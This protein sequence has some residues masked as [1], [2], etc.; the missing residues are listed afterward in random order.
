MKC[1][2]CERE[3]LRSTV[4]VGATVSTAMCSYSFYDED[5]K[6]HYHNPNTV[7]TSYRCSNGHTW[8]ESHRN[9]CWCEKPSDPPVAPDSSPRS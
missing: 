5:G 9:P 3:G 1:Q 2:T 7:G 6:Y 8:H 4:H